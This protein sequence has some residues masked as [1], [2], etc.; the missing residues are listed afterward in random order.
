MPSKIQSLRNQAFQLQCGRCWY[1]GVQMWRESPSELPNVHERS[2]SRLRCTAEH[3]V[4]QCDGGKHEPGNVVAACAHCNQ[5]RHKR[6]KPPEPR[7]YRSIVQNR[8]SRGSWHHL[9]VRE[10]GLLLPVS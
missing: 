5:T 10:Y 4:A 7:P 8:V 1:C 9:W 3:L 2:A 6:K